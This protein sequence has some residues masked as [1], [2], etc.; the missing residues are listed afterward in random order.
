MRPQPAATRPT[1]DTATK[2]NPSGS[3]VDLY[4]ASYRNFTNQL[5]ADIRNEAFGEDIGQTSWLTAEEQDLF[6][7]WLGLS[8]ASNLLDVAC[9][10]GKPTLRIAQKIRCRV[11]GIDLH[12]DGIA[13]ANVSPKELGQEQRA[14]FLQADAAERHPFEDSSFDAIMCIDAMLARKPL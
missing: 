11:F 3:G 8:E 13:S 12:N 6:I 9:G 7:G 5:Y 10:L 14:Q 2:M 1:S 4:G